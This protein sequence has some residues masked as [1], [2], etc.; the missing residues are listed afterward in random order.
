[1]SEF[2]DLHRRDAPRDTERDVDPCSITE[3][4]PAPAAYKVP[5]RN[6]LP[7]D[8]QVARYSAI[9]TVISS[10]S[11]AS[12]NVGTVRSDDLDDVLPFEAPERAP[13]LVD[14]GGSRSNASR[15]ALST[16]TTDCERSSGPATT[17]HP[18]LQLGD[19]DR[20]RRGALRDGV[21]LDPGLDVDEVVRLG[22]RSDQAVVV[23]GSSTP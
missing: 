22:G 7:T 17:K 3:T 5:L 6:A 20:L 1:V 10:R 8:A 18:R 9:S 4:V 16:A 11:T 12:L 14:V 21:G 23:A 19:A 15:T 2:D 13:H